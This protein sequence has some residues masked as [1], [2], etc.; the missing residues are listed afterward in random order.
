MMHPTTQKKLGLVLGAAIL[1]GF[2]LW[3]LAERSELEGIR[4]GEPRA[5]AAAPDWRQATSAWDG[6]HR[7][8]VRLVRGGLGDPRSFAHVETVYRDFGDSIN[9]AMR[10]RAANRFGGMEV[11][12]ARANICAQTGEVREWWGR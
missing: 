3:V 10:Y 2:G 7:E 11:F 6:H 12:E 8:L 5:E 1:L 9:V 4:S